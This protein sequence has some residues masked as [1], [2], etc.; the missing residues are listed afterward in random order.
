MIFI[1][2][3]KTLTF[4][5]SQILRNNNQNSIIFT[6]HLHHIIQYIHILAKS[7]N[8]FYVYIIY[9]HIHQIIFSFSI[10]TYTCLHNVMLYRAQSI[11]RKCPYG[12]HIIGKK[13]QNACMNQSF[14]VA[15][16]PRRLYIFLTSQCLEQTL[17]LNFFISGH[18][19]EVFIF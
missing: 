11:I 18:F 17:L 5:N 4:C 3:Y 1:L 8:Q 12:L 13:L 2:K 7:T 19:C 10:R 9:K 14:S 6:F 16:L 15:S